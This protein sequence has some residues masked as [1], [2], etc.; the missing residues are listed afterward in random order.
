MTKKTVNG[1]ATTY[2]YGE[3]NELLSAGA[4]T[5]D[6]DLN[7]NLVSS[8]GGLSLAYNAKNQTTNVNGTAMSY[9][10]ADQTRRVDAGTKHFTYSQ[11]GLGTEKDA[12]GTTAYTRDNEGTLVSMRAP[13]G[14]SYY[15]LENLLAST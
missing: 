2:I 1:S 15:L 10:D 4:T 11:L 9:A 13:A 7:G 14:T 6:Y 3:A 12:G 5:Y 8:S